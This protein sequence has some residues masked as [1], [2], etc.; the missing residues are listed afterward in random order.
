MGR[1]TTSVNTILMSWHLFASVF[2][3]ESVSL[4]VPSWL[5]SASARL[6]LGLKGFLQSDDLLL[7]ELHCGIVMGNINYSKSK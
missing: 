4:S 5:L 6:R 3:L 2:Q 7:C 1:Y